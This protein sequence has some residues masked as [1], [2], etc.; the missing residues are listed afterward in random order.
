M[1]G[2]G[3]CQY[4]LTSHLFQRKVTAGLAVSGEL[5]FSI[6][7]EKGHILGARCVSTSSAEGGE[8]ASS[9]E[10]NPW[11]LGFQGSQL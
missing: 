8:T 11:N 6:R 10:V 7:D 3:K 4:C 1:V 5:T 2:S 9:G